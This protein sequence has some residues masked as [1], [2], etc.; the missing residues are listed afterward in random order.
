MLLTEL[1][2]IVGADHL[3]TDADVTAAEGCTVVSV[4]LASLEDSGIVREVNGDYLADHAHLS[5]AA[6][7]HGVQGETTDRA[8]VGPGVDA[9]GLYVGLTRGREHNAAVVVADNDRAAREQLV[10]MMQRGRIEATL[11]DARTAARLDLSHAARRVDVPT[12]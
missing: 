7:V 12:R 10:E 3:L 9:A 2:A 6:T 1:R 5:Y 11:D 8:L 4:R